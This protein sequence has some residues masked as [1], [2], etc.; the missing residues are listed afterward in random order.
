MSDAAFQ[1]VF[2]TFSCLNAEKFYPSNGI[3]VIL[4]FTGKLDFLDFSDFHRLK[5]LS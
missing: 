3:F 5:N 2:Y 1:T 4:S